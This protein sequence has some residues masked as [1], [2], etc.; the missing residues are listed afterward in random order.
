MFIINVDFFSN[1][2]Q[3]FQIIKWNF[4]LRKITICTCIY[5]ATVLI[6]S[7]KFVEKN[8]KGLLL[9]GV[10]IT[11]D[12]LCALG[13]MTEIANHKACSTSVCVGNHLYPKAVP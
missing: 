10:L 1:E 11:V 9:N 6:F 12:F 5:K 13:S 3:R 8:M 7:N 2:L 4:P